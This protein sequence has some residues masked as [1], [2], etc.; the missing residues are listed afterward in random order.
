MMTMPTPVQ[1]PSVED[2]AESA[3]AHTVG[4]GSN[5]S[6]AKVLAKPPVRK[7]AKDLGVDLTTLVPSGDGGVVTRADVESAAAGGGA[8]G[9]GAG[10]RPG[11]LASARPASRSR[12]CGR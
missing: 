4:G 2:I 9:R 10:V 12:G 5:G 1:E 3:P 7:L 6:G 11:A 8:G